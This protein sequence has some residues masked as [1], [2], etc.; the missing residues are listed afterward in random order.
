MI[1]KITIKVL[2]YQVYEIICS[3]LEM[4]RNQAIN[5]NKEKSGE[6]PLSFKE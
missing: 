5:S 3:I 2:H 1:I 4:T 6:D